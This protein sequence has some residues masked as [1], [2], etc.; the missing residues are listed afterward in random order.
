M[1][2]FIRT[3]EG[4]S[5]AIAQAS[6]IEGRRRRPQS[7]RKNSEKKEKGKWKKENIYMYVFRRLY[8]DCSS[9]KI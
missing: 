7:K 9:A 4:P 3:G 1:V 2:A 5:L 8:S 6:C